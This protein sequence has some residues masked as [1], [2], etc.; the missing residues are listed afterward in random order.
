MVCKEHWEGEQIKE[1]LTFSPQVW[2][3]KSSCCRDTWETT[4]SGE[5]RLTVKKRGQGLVY[6]HVTCAVV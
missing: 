6:G 1:Q 4:S 2:E 5:G 3:N